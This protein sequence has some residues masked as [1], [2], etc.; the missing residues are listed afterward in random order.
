MAQGS[1]TIAFGD[2]NHGFEVGQSYGPISA[3]IHLPPERPETPP[4]PS[5]NVP[6]PQDLD[7]VNR[8]TLLDQICEKLSVPASRAALVGLVGVGK[9]QLAIEHSYQVRKKSPDT[10]VFWV[11]GSNAAR[12][13]QSFRQ[14]ADQVKITGRR[15]PKANIFQLVYDWLHD[16]KKGKW[17]LVLDNRAQEGGLNSGIAQPLLRCLP[18]SGNG[19]VLVTT[20]SRDI[21]LKLVG[22]RNIIDVELMDERQAL[23][24][25]ET[26]LGKQSNKKDIAELAAALEFMPLALIQAAA[27]IKARASRFS[28][29]QYIEKFQRSDRAKTSLLDYDA[30]HIYRD[31]Q[32]K[33]SILITWQ[34]SF[35]YIFQTRRSAAGLLSLMSFFDR[36]GIPEALIRP[37]SETGNRHENSRAHSEDRKER[38]DEDSGSEAS[39]DD[40]FED[41]IL[42]LRDY[43]FISLTKDPT[44]FEMHMLVQLA[45]R[46]WLEGQG[47]L[48]EWRQQYIKNICIGFPDGSYGNWPICQT[49]FPHAKSALAQQP[50]GE[51][52][53]GEWA[54]LSY[55]AAWYA[56]ARGTPINAEKMS[57]RSM[58]VRKTLLGEEHKDTLSS[59]AMVALAYNFRG[60]WKEAEELGMQSLRVLGK[61]HPSTLTSMANLASTYWNQG[62][63]KEAE[64]LGLQV[65]ETRKRVLGEEHP[66][67]LTSMANLAHI[68]KSQ[69]RN[70]DAISL[71]RKCCQLQEQIL[72]PQHPHTEESLETLNKWQI[73]NMKAGL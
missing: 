48:E 4:S 12:F 69:S 49:Y 41:D 57:I 14:V 39:A 27:Y 40:G 66:S 73:E 13:E 15:N 70:E 11:H 29:R 56:W 31:W 38:D 19:T 43:S 32:A 30:G 22:E 17:V 24:L 62:R 2:S 33:N 50:E 1:A 47:Q 42:I 37:Q 8:G 52:S 10:W 36:Q 67:T 65:M 5:A 23:A 44:T 59:M 28:V 6:F 53:L 26:K 68:L 54:L 55:H 21:A 58:K 45:T 9:S 7:F 16:E 3:E 61:E 46:K 64:E 63:W 71:M 72:G 34:I 35:D 18:C 51:D 25:I 60:R 20:R